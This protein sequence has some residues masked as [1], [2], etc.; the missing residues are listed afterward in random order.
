MKTTA[1]VTFGSFGREIE[2]YNSE[3][4]ILLGANL[5]V[6]ERVGWIERNTSWKFYGATRSKI[7]AGR[8]FTVEHFDERLAPLE[9][10]EFESLQACKDAV[11]AAL[12]KEG[13]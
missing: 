8:T 1:K 13:K 2:A 10:V 4:D 5:G 9:G 7:V 12:A 11:R 6:A 3:A